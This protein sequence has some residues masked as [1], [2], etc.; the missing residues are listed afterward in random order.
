MAAT[1]Q[2]RN[3]RKSGAK[4]HE[5]N[6]TPNYP[7]FN[8]T[9]RVGRLAE[10]AATAT[11]EDKMNSSRVPRRVHPV[12]SSYAEMLERELPKAAPPPAGLSLAS[13]FAG[14]GG[15]DLGFRSAGFELRF[16]SDYWARAAETFGACLGHV[17]LV[18]DIREVVGEKL[19]P[20]VGVD[21]LTGGF[22]CVT[23]STAGRRMGVQDDVAGKLYLEL[24][25]VIDQCRPRYFIA[26][27]VQGILS[28]N[29]GAAV[30]LVAAAFLRLGYRVDWRLVNMAEHSVA[31]TRMR[32]IFVGVRLDQWRGSFRFPEKTR[33]LRADARAPRWLPLA[34]SLLDAIGDL[35]DPDEDVL[36]VE[37]GD[38]AAK[39]AG[40]GV[41]AYH[42]SQPRAANDPS[43][44]QTTASNVLHVRRIKG[45]R[46]TDFFNPR[47]DGDAPS[48]SVTTVPP[49]LTIGAINAYEKSAARG[50][51]PSTSCTEPSPTA[52]ATAPPLLVNHVPNRAPV[53][54]S[55]NMSKR[56]AR[57]ALPSPTQV[58][59]AE[60]VVPFVERHDVLR[61]MTVRE[62][63][64]VQSF[65]DWY[66]FAGSAA[67]GY[68]QV[69]NAVPP[70]YA[71]RLAEAILEYDKREVLK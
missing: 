7:K 47:R 19:A 14:C 70:L 29:G 12:L 8:I 1:A 57:G 50:R 59:E 69:G 71:K 67:D 37:H 3:Q 25:R 65:P 44:S 11:A 34:A 39:R 26:E 60:N 64:R 56:V 22:P 53:S 33:R 32:V 51:P 5:V 23:F 49:E 6:P 40:P 54:A 15:I 52:V 27:N 35:P 18:S 36:A 21:V 9:N 10:P 17:P 46:N 61:R 2:K 31:Q 58:S 16:A 43:H 38:A 30:K 68:R 48:V 45:A 66:E 42:S 41:S 28:A 63:A 55:H 62:C 24:C 4:N 13:F 20:A